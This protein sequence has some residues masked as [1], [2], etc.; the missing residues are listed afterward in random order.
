[1]G[2]SEPVQPWCRIVPVRIGSRNLSIQ[3]EDSFSLKYLHK[4][5]VC[6]IISRF[7]TVELLLPC[8][9]N[10]NCRGV[11]ISYFHLN[12]TTEWN[13]KSITR[14]SDK[15]SVDTGCNM[16]WLHTLSLDKRKQTLFIREHRLLTRDLLRN[17]SL[18]IGQAAFPI[19]IIIIRQSLV[20]SMKVI[21]LLAKAN[22]LLRQ[23]SPLNTH[24]R[25]HI[26]RLPVYISSLAHRAPL[27]DIHREKFHVLERLWVLHCATAF[28]QW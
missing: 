1:M 7:R 28:F 25:L 20:T 26:S 22:K 21:N 3:Q 11:Y 8:T 5:I 19:I 4:I 27:N 12:L 9:E 17:I 13:V 6:L 24:N 14:V 2:S 23:N 10:V 16:L 18:N 15:Y